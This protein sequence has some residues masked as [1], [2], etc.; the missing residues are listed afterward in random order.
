MTANAVAKYLKKKI[1]LVTVS[2]LNESQIT[3]V[4]TAVLYNCSYY[5]ND[6][7]IHRIYFGSYSVKPRF[8]TQ[9]YSSTNVNQ[10]SS[11]E[12]IVTMSS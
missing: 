1:L 12:T 5:D 2:L 6:Q 10:Y 9:S 11:P 4:S 8:T 3:K 7:S